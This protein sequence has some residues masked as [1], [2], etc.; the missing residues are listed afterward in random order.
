MSRGSG[1]AGASLDT[2]GAGAIV[3]RGIGDALPLFLPAIPFA[4]VIGVTVLDS[5]FAPLLGWST[6]LFIYGGAAQLTLLVLLADGAAA[7]AAITA[8]LIVNA[9]HLM[10][11]AALAPAFQRQ[12][13]WFRWLGPYLLIDQVFALGILRTGLAPRPFRLYYLSLGMTFWLLWLLATGVALVIGPVIPAA[14]ELDFAVPV[15]FLA[16]V[17]MTIDR[18]PKLAAAIAAAVVAWLGAD[19]PHRSGLLLGAAAGIACGL[20]AERLRA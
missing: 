12:P 17:V 2:A 1:P 3:R 10:Y 16:L 5:G 11:S 8:A 7:A 4:L 9:R 19:L 14:W 18:W 15:M 13:V 20:L 6:S